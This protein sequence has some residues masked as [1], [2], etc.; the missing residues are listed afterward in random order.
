MEKKAKEHEVLFVAASS[1][2]GD[3]YSLV[4]VRNHLVCNRSVYHEA[5]KACQISTERQIV[6]IDLN[7]FPLS[8]KTLSQL[9]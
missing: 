6:A 3:T 4:P 9:Q 8:P 2:M 5:G 1:L 7:V